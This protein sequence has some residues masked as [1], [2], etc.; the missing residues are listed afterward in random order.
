MQRSVHALAAAYGLALLVA[1]VA[2]AAARGGHPI[3]VAIAADVAATVVVFAF[4]FAVGNS[5]LYDPYWS[6][7]P[8]PIALW[9]IAAGGEGPPVERRALVV[10]LVAAWGARLTWNWWRGW[11]GL[12][13]EDW[14]YERI[15]ERSGRAYWLASFAGIHLFPTAMVLLGCLPLWPALGV[16]ARP[17]GW[18]DALAFA[19][20]AGAI[21]LEA[22]ADQQLRRFRTRADRRPDAILEEGLWRWSRHPNY[23]GEMGFWWGLW[24][25]AVAAAPGWAWTAVGPLAMTAMFLFA[26]IPMLERRMAERRPDWPDHAARVSRLLPRPPKF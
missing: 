23:L 21:A 12:D 19:V 14:R 7:A 8:L 26:S 16:G 4:S 10:L 11:G 18:L 2:G 13:H 5:S 24:L 20:T 15:R 25:F 22:I 17:L 9:W 1:L 3:E 6:V